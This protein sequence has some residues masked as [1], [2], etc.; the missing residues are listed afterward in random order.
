[1]Q[2]LANTL[3]AAKIDALLRKWAISGFRKY[4]Q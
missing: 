3:S 4:K 1:M 2:G